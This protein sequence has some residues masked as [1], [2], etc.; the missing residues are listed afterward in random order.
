MKRAAPL[1]L[2]IVLAGLAALACSSTPGPSPDEPGIIN[3]VAGTGIAAF[4]GDGDLATESALYAPVKVGFAPAHGPLIIDWNNH[5]VREL[6]SNG[7]LL[8]IIGTGTEDLGQANVV[9]IAFSVHHPF[10][11]ETS[12]SGDIF[13]AGFHDPRIYKIDNAQRVRM[14]AGSGAVGNTGDEDIAQLAR[15]NNPAGVAVALDGTVYFT[16]A[17]NHQIRKVG[18]DELLHR[19]AGNGQRGYSGDGGPAKDA[20]LN[21]PTRIDFDTEGSLIVVDSDNHA[22]RKIDPQGIITT[23]AGTGQPGYSGDGGPAKAAQLSTPTDIALLDDGRMLI[24]DSQ[25]HVLRMIDAQGIITTLAGTAT[26]GFAGDGGPLSGA[27]FNSPTGIT[28]DPSDGSVWIAD[29]GNNRIRR[30]NKLP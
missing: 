18:E 16:E 1:C 9:S 7:K 20:L 5:R 23:I 30:I 13:F 12:A 21:G 14:I 28:V 25:N 17:T 29:T 6:L 2:A 3:T 10:D 11:L 22:I 15:M 8:T 19:I 27:A 4:T 26:T 24:A